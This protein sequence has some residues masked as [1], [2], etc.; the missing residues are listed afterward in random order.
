M[1][2]PIA[3]I[4]VLAGFSVVSLPA[5]AV[6]SPK[7]SQQIDMFVE[8]NLK[9]NRLQP[10]P[11]S[12]DEEFLRRIYLDIIGRIPTAEEAKAFLDR[13]SPTKRSELIN[14]LLDSDG[15]VSHTFN[16]WAD[17]LRVQTEQQNAGGVEYANWVKNAIRENMPYD[18]FVHQLISASGFTWDNGAVGYYLRDAGMPLDNMSNTTQIFLGT[19]LV[20]AQCHDHPFDRWKQMEYFQMAA[21]TYNTVDTRIRP[22]T[23]LGL[24][25][26]MER[27][28]RRGNVDRQLRDAL[29]DLFE[30]LSY[31]VQEVNRELKLP[32]DYKYKDGDPNEPVRPRAMFSEPSLSRSKKNM[33]ENYADWLT[34]P[35]NPRFTHVIA[36]RLW[37]RVM[38]RG[39]VEPV[40]DWKDDTEPSNRYVLDHLVRMLKQN[41]YDQKEILR[42][43]FNTRTYQR[44]CYGEDIPEDTPYHFPG[45]VLRRMSAE[46]FWDSFMT[47]AVPGVDDRRGDYANRGYSRAKQEADRL[48]SMN[49]K[50]I[51]AMA[52]RIAEQNREFDER[53]T[54]L[55]SQMADARKAGN[56]QRAQELQRELNTLNGQKDQRI[57]EIKKETF[58][59]VDAGKEEGGLAMMRRDDEPAMMMA[60]QKMKEGE[61][62]VA[63]SRNWDGYD[64]GFVRASEL[65]SPADNG[66]F[67]R[68]F[69]QSDREII[70][71][72]SREPS[73]DQALTLLNSP[74]FD[75]MFHDKSKLAIDLATAADVEEK[76]NLVF[77]ALLS[78]YPRDEERELIDAQISQY[79]EEKAFRNV[80]WALMN[81]QE[82]CFLQ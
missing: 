31:G 78:R 5:P 26:D 12:T 55:R 49:P 82:F 61:T 40:D 38:G 24:D 36:N 74:I 34:S 43:L 73:V 21:F 9:R 64:K 14:E 69:G 47:V 44:Q 58:A 42:T 4:V 30:P 57:A 25:K 70:Q 50:D 65:R 75:Q 60:D 77:L 19:R 59:S 35:E 56:G 51:L 3:M 67:L 22:E 37:K 20:C 16:W 81:T 80:A 66:H 11:P 2:H 6:A 17:I 39:L 63:G 48:L 18:Q 41:R 33:R 62:P 76:K 72:A 45:P 10:L 68:Q 46:Q 79:G 8:Q 15:Y 28:N 29:N 54:A 27:A 13:E 52:E 1:K 53:A 71:N 23:L 32:H 7:D